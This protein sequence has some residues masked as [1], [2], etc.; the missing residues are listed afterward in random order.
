VRGEWC[1]KPNEGS[2]LDKYSTVFVGY[3]TYHKL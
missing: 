1:V 2:P 3:M